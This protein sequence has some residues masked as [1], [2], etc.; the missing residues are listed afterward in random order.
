[1]KWFKDG[2]PLPASNRFTTTYD[3]NTGVARLSIANCLLNDAGVYTVIA[4]NKAGSDKTSGRLEVEKE[5]I[6]D[7]TPII[8]PD[9]FNYLNRPEQASRPRRAPDDASKMTPPKIV[10]PLSDIQTIEGKP[11]RLVSK[12]EG[13]PKPTVIH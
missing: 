10:V 5:S 1:L 13:N 12:V 3:L 11:C 9:A 7:T 8:N 4:E 6:I 2:A